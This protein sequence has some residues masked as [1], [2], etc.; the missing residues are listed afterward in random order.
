MFSFLHIFHVRAA[1]IAILYVSLEAILGK[2]FLLQVTKYTI[3]LI[4]KQYDGQYLLFSFLLLFFL[5]LFWRA[6][7]K[8]GGGRV[9][10]CLDPRLHG[11]CRINKGRTI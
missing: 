6:P 4:G 9:L 10:P 1:L 8:R 2:T 7:Q 3:I 11:G 5:L